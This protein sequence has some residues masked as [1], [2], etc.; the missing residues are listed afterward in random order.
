MILLGAC[1]S[2]P[3]PAA[4][5]EPPRPPPPVWTDATRAAAI[6]EGEAVL[7]KHECRRCHTIDALPDPARPLHCTSCHQFIDGL[8]PDDPLYTKIAE[9][10]GHDV[11]QRYQDNIS[12]LKEVPDLSRLGARVRPDWIPGFLAEPFDLRPVLEESMIRNKLTEPERLAIAR[13]FAAVADRP[14]PAHPDFRPPAPPARPSDPEM[15]RAREL[16]RAKACATC[17]TVGNVDFGVTAGQLVAAAEITRLAPNLRFVR[18]R[19]DPADAAR[20]ILDPQAV[21]P[22]AKMPKL[23]LSPAEAELLVAWLFHVDPELKPTPASTPAPA[24]PP[25]E[26]EVGWAEVKEEVL[27]DVCVHC[28]MNDHEKDPGPGNS[29]GLGYLGVGLS[30]RTYEAIVAGYG[31]GVC[32]SLEAQGAETQAALVD[33]MLKRRVEALRDFVAPFDDYERPPYPPG[34]SRG[35]P[36]GL[37]PRSDAQIQLVVSWIAQDC[38]GPHEVTGTPGVDDGFLVPDGPIEKNVGCERRSPAKERPA[39]AVAPPKPIP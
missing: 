33:T 8:K 35:M 13:Y 24:P 22:G 21:Q 11:L 4:P 34:A 27:G 7:V 6:Q 32:T 17:H 25:L 29:G 5:P 30:M 2:D 26:R 15:A 3:E 36:M 14:D 28:H 19:M 9:K 10:N 1:S 39:W 16:F 12:H 23:G 20:W 18:E 31:P 37:P 38:P